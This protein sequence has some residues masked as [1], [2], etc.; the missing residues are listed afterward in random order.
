MELSNMAHEILRLNQLKY[1]VVR[2]QL[3]DDL[4][5]NFQETL[6]SAEHL[7][8]EWFL[9]NP[10]KVCAKDQLENIGWQGRPVSSSSLS[11]L[12]HSLRKKLAKF[13]GIEIKN[14]PQQG[15]V[16][17][18]E[19]LL[20]PQEPTISTPSQ[21]TPNRF[22]AVMFA[23]ASLI[24]FITLFGVLRSPFTCENYGRSYYCYIGVPSEE[25]RTKARENQERKLF[26]YSTQKSEEINYESF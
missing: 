9:N 24:T 21:K 18:V 17:T 8:L 3:S 25:A 10:G 1:D 4:N 5:P 19:Q 26:V 22:W 11:V 2:Y 13:E 14:I 6:S 12:L 20:S 7:I 23:L 15:Y 16:L